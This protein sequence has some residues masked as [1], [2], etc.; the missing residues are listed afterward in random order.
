M[1]YCSFGST[2]QGTCDGITMIDIG[3]AKDF[4]D[5]RA[6]VSPNVRDVFNTRNFNNTGTTDGNSN[7]DFYSVRQFSWSNQSIS[8]NIQCFFGP[9]QQIPRAMWARQR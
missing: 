7:T 8:I 2:S 9:K 3:I 6:K 1:Y 5:G 4:M